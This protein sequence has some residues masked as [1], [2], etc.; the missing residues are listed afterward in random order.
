MAST[1]MH[2]VD[3][4]VT[5]GYPYSDKRDPEVT[6]IDLL[7]PGDLDIV[8][9]RLHPQPFRYGW[10]CIEYAPL[11]RDI[12]QSLNGTDIMIIIRLLTA[13]A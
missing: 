8:S 10:T 7:S 4:V 5:A 11:Q 2:K 9:R 3:S 13:T 1:V 6:S 12:K